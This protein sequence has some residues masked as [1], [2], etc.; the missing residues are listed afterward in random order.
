MIESS[1]QAA[2]F[3]SGLPTTWFYFLSLPKL[4]LACCHFFKLPSSFFF[5]S[6]TWFLSFSQFLSHLIH[7]WLLVFW[8]VSL[9]SWIFIYFLAFTQPT[10]ELVFEVEKKGDERDSIWLTT[11]AHPPRVIS[12]WAWLYSCP[13]K[14]RNM[15]MPI[16]LEFLSQGNWLVET[17]LIRNSCCCSV[18]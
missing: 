16:L 12:P 10:I 3:S 14:F 13:W 11:P 7:F 4:V 5:F 18:S 15:A 6:L 17:R 2:K 8:E 1:I 9:P